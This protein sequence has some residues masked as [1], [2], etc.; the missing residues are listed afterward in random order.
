MTQVMIMHGSDDLSQYD[1]R[2]RGVG[3]DV[4]FKQEDKKWQRDLDLIIDR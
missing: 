1:P 3:C 2:K 4:H